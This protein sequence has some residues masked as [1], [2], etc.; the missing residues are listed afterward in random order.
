MGALCARAAAR[1][2]YFNVKINLGGITA[3]GFKADVLEE[4]DGLLAQADCLEREV[5][6]LVEGRVSG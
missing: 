6:T 4:A 2:A 5:L 3:Q 1:G